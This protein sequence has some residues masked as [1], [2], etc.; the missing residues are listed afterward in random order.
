MQPSIG[1]DA[2]RLP[3]KFL[4]MTRGLDGLQDG[5]QACLD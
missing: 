1:I 3:G 2:D 5:M 4:D